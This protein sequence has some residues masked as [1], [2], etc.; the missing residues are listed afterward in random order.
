MQVASFLAHISSLCP[1]CLSGHTSF[2]TTRPLCGAPPTVRVRAGLSDAQTGLFFLK[3]PVATTSTCPQQ[4]FHPQLQLEGETPGTVLPS[5]LPRQPHIFL[6]SHSRSLPRPFFCLAD[7][8]PLP[9][10]FRVFK[11]GSK[12]AS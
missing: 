1:C 10:Q 12:C 9:F 4:A 2:F 11:V 3:E 6:T 8:S 7:P 5:C